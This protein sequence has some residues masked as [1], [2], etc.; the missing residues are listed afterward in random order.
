ME[1][2]ETGSKKRPAKKD[3]ST[4]RSTSSTSQKKAEKSSSTTDDLDIVLLCNPKAG[5]RWKELADILDSMEA[6]QVR[7]IVTDSINDIG[8]AL[9]DIGR[10]TKLICIY[11]GDGTIQRILNRLIQLP[12]EEQPQL[13]FIGGG[14]MNVTASWCGMTRSPGKNFRTVI[15]AY[16][17]GELLLR[18]VPLLTVQQGNVL[19]HGFTFGIGPIIRVLNHYELGNK[20]KTAAASIVLRSLLACWSKWPAEYEPVLRELEGEILVDDKPLPYKRYSAV[21]CNVTGR[22]NPGV[23][24]FVKTRTRDTF[25]YGAYAVDRRE[26]SLLF[27]LLIRGRLPID[28]KN[29]LKPMST[30]KQMTLSLIGKESFPVDPRYVNDIASRFEI[31]SQEKFYTVDGEII[32]SNGE[33]IT[34]TLGPSLKLAVSS[35]VGLGPTMRLAA[36]VTKLKALGN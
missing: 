3:S 32:S 34:V 11:G 6:Q 10:K 31:R 33:P 12:W 27:P 17:S 8:P 29:L 14:T 26:F 2:K 4:K 1:K 20:G 35:T 24:P 18:E 36:D 15:N 16:T 30:W 13:A 25:Y 19:H 23:E 7:R 21:F 9:G 28:T 22:I 5:G